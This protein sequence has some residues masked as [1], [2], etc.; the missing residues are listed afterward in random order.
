MRKL[1][2]IILGVVMSFSLSVATLADNTEIVG[3]REKLDAL[4]MTRNFSKEQ[5][6]KMD[7]EYINNFNDYFWNTQLPLLKLAEK[8]GDRSDDEQ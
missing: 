5:L 3:L 2:C 8:T 6:D 4:I 7:D 1:I